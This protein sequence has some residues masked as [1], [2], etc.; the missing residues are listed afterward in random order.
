M[1]NFGIMALSLLH[2]DVP[3][4]DQWGFVHNRRFYLYVTTRDFAASEVSPG[5]LHMREMLAACH[6]A[7]IDTADL[8][9]PAMPYKLT[10][11]TGTVAVTDYALDLTWRGR[12]VTRIWDGW[13]R[14]LLKH[15][16]LAMPI[17]PRTLLMRLARRA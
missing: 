13:L 6:A 10:W 8:M 4:S 1:P 16:V 2:G 12:A 5:K 3:I 15:T 14:P 17:G 11:A 9:V 7:G